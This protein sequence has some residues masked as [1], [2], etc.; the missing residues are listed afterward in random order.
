MGFVGGGG[1]IAITTALPR[2]SF[3]YCI[4]NI[5]YF[6]E[7]LSLIFY[8]CPRLRFL[9]VEINPGQRLPVPAVCR[10]LRSNVRGLAGNL[11]DLT[12]A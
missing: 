12:M 7:Y 4:V 9:D 8:A 3:L 2:S 5:E 6:M 11:S 1:Y 10:I